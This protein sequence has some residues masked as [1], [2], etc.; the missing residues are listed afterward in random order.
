LN[1]TA[2]PTPSNYQA[3]VPDYLDDPYEGELMAYFMYFYGK[4]PNNQEREQIWKF[5]IQANKLQ[6]VDYQTPVGP[7]TVQRGYWFSAH[8]QWKFMVLP[9]REVPLINRV[10]MNCERARTLNSHFKKIPGMFASVNDVTKGSLD[11]PDYI[12]AAGI[13]GITFE[14][15]QRTDVVTPYSSFPTILA[16]QTV[17]LVWYHLMLK[18]PRMQGPYGSTEAVNRNGTEISPLTTWDSKITSVVAILGGI[19]KL[20]AAILNEEKLMSQ[21]LFVAHRDYSRV[22]SEL[23]GEQLPLGLPTAHIPLDT[24]GHFPTCN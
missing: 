23:K 10:F 6:S 7:V 3:E 21:F 13:S 11:I 24:L 19:T 2:V 9:F 14:S 4:W 12:S 8:E 1:T 16:N 17:G 18:G 5:K 20:T 22:F 15:V